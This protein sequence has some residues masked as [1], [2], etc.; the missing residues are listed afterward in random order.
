[1]QPQYSR[2]GDHRCV[3]S[4]ELANVAGDAGIS[5]AIA[6]A[7]GQPLCILP[8]APSCVPS[9]PGYE[10]AAAVFG[11]DTVSDMLGMREIAGLAEVME[12]AG[13]VG[14]DPRVRG[15]VQA[16]LASRKPV[17]A[18][19]RGLEGSGLQAHAAA[20]IASDHELTSASDLM[21]MLRAS[22][23]IELRGSH[24]HLLPEFAHALADL[25]HLPP[26]VT[27]CTDDV[28]P[29]DLLEMG[30]LDAVL[31]Q[32]AGHGLQ[33]LRI[34]QAATLNAAL[35]L[36]RPD[37]GLVA[38]GRRSDLVLFRDLVEFKAVHVYCD[39]R[40]PEFRVDTDAA[41]L[42]TAGSVRPLAPE[43]FDITANGPFARA[44]TIDEPRFTRWTE[45]RM[46]V[47]SGVI[48]PPDEVLRMT[49]VHRHGQSGWRPRTGFL[50]GW[51]RWDGA[52]AAT[53]SHDSHN[54]TVF[55]SR[56]T[57]MAVA[58]NAVIEAGGGMAVAAGGE[59]R[60]CLALPVAGLVSDAPLEDVAAGFTAV[61][62]AM[63]GVADWKPPNRV[64][65]A[66]VGASPACNPGPRPTDLGIADPHAGILRSSPVIEDGLPA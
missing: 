60:A 31:R 4:H 20:G 53:V 66:L 16:G 51:G 55:G 58:A 36:G 44:Y 34:L 54:L 24:P 38:P 28:F 27:L 12:I 18:H 65:K 33:P 25:P 40:P 46:G 10:T 47:R 52:F 11:P 63:D 49:I 43:D 32:L 5:Y 50:T 19:A 2:E 37:L 41:V 48:A 29:D 62:S 22:L 56:T 26:T 3:G 7:S 35:R 42:P 64:F 1:M 57:D 6:S 14:R 15:I 21:E 61:R 45:D 30:G 39:G 8:L 59:V 13:V 17:C 9:A 23:T